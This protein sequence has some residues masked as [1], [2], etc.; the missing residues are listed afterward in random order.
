MI[1]AYVPSPKANIILNRF[2]FSD[3]STIGTLN[4]DQGMFEAFTLEDTVRRVKKFGETA[5]PSG[6]YK[7]V[8]MNSHKFGFVPHL[9]D[10]PYYTDILMHNG[11]APAQT[12]GCLLIGRYDPQQK[13]WIGE[14]R[15]TLKSLMEVLKPLNEKEALWIEIRGGFTKDQM[16]LT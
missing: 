8:L 4:V 5:I 12:F 16:S 3:E 6:I 14:S 15:A 13:N 1:D 2:E 7:V 11:N 10:V 9:L